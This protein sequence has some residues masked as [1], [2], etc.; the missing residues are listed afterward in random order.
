MRC[1][2][3]ARHVAWRHRLFS[4]SANS[5]AAPRHNAACAHGIIA[6]V[7]QQR[8]A[9]RLAQRHQRGIGSGMSAAAAHLR[10]SGVEISEIC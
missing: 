5:I 9:Q 6:P 10:Q 1:V 8:C 2:A 3:A 4:V 7:T